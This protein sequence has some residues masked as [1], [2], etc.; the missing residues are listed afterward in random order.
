M[1]AKFVY[2][3]GVS[4]QELLRLPCMQVAPL[5]FAAQYTFNLSLSET[6]VTSNT[7]L[8]STS[9]LFT[10]GLSCALLLEAFLL[11][12][13]AFIFLCMAGGLLGAPHFIIYH[14]CFK[15]PCKL[16]QGKALSVMLRSRKVDGKFVP[17][18]ARRW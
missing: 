5:W 16:C 9:S 2:V 17:G 12:K 10:Y 14:S 4:M 3:E 15:Q 18:Q 1:P 8:A 11:P 7:I 13:L 6:T